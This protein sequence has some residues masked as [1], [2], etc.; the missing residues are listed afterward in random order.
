MTPGRL[1]PFPLKETGLQPVF[2]N[3]YPYFFGSKIPE[4]IFL[5]IFVQN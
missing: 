1:S 3:V 2:F 4:T 5:S